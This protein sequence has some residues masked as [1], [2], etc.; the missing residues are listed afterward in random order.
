MPLALG[1]NYL[2]ADFCFGQSQ[3][4]LSDLGAAGT[5][6]FSILGLQGANIQLIAVALQVN[7]N[8]GIGVNGLMHL[9]GG[10]TLQSTLYADPSATVQID[11]GS[12]FAGG[13]IRISFTAI[14][15]G[16]LA[17]SASAALLPPT[18]TFSQIQTATTIVGNGGQNVIAVNG[19]IHLSGGQNPTISGGPNDTF[20]FNCA[21]GFQL[22]GGANVIL[23][24]ASPNNLLFNFP[25]TGQQVQ[26]S[27][28]ANTAGIFLAPNEAIQINGAFT[29]ACSFPEACSRSSRILSSTRSRPARRPGRPGWHHRRSAC[30]KLMGVTVGVCRKTDDAIAANQFSMTSGN[31][32]RFRGSELPV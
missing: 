7:G 21:Q 23:N 5:Y 30:L 6:G 20:I 12:S 19:Q 28:K 9:S 22:D 17:F 29:T 31:E 14:Q 13:T 24:G 32:R 3:C 26:T 16:A 10:A 25:G 18:Q 8:V 11:G 4:L 27:G 15:R 1:Q 2:H